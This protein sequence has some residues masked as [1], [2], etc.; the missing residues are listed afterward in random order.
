MAAKYRKI[1]P[2]VWTDESFAELESVEKLVA[3]YAITAQSN[4]C[5]LFRFSPARAAEETGL[6]PDSYDGI[7]VRV[8][9][10]LA[11]K[12]DPKRRVLYLPSWWKYNPPENPKHLKGCLEDLHDLP[13][14]PLLTEFA[15]NVRHLPEHCRED[16]SIAMQIAM[17]NQE[18]KQEQ[19]QKKKKTSA[20][21][22]SA[23][24]D[25]APRAVLG[26]NRS[27]AKSGATKTKTATGTATATVEGEA[28]STAANPATGGP[29]EVR[30]RPPARQPATGPHHEFIRHFCDRWQEKYGDTYAFLAGKDGRHVQW[31]LHVLVGNLEKAKEIVD[32]YLA[33]ED[34]FIA[35]KKHPLGLLVSN[36]NKHK[37]GSG[38]GPAR[39]GASHGKR[40]TAGAG[41]SAFTGARRSLPDVVA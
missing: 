14:S 1:D 26:V 8:C 22:E 28:S 18:Q 30:S 9:H 34:P 37:V 6:D 36:F 41:Q 11:W 13:Y 39:N 17:A 16:F 29:S 25:D 2:R 24:A 23:A 10:T 33:D 7:F 40:S 31:I 4:R 27:G 3:L 21:A 35:D 38:S 15:T 32:R 12:Y 19:E 20:G 5:G